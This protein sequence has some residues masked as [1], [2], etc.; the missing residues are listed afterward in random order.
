[1]KSPKETR[2]GLLNA[3]TDGLLVRIRSPYHNGHVHG[4]VIDV[5]PK[6]FL[7]RSVSDDIRY[8]GFECF[9]IKDVRGLKPAPTASFMIAALA[10]R[11]PERPADPIVDLSSLETLL[12]TASAAFPLITL[13]RERQRPDACWIGKMT[14]I[15]EGQ[16]L[17]RTVAPDATWD[18]EYDCF[19]L[20][21]ITRVGFGADYE[22]ALDL[23]AGVPVD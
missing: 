21:S 17:M 2:E 22:A 13:H 9:R 3:K 16:V 20:K 5:G 12:R 4:Y 11:Y 10:L 18:Y 15:H 6:F 8:N 23:V 1:M 19:A 7:L 14:D